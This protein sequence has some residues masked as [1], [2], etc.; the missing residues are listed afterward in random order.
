MKV[1][2]QWL[3]DFVEV[4]GYS[5]QELSDVFN[6]IG[7]EVAAVTTYC[8]PQGVVLG[9]VET[10]EKHPDAEKLHVCHVNVGNEV[11]QIVCGAKNIRQGVFVAIAT[12]GTLL[13]NN[14]MIK[15]AK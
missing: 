3:N 7:H 4:S 2:K 5:T 15:K 8:V 11:L 14:I 12:I 6:R 1:S 13:P 9:F 10:C